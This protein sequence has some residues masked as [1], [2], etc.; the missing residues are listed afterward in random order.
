MSQDILTR[1]QQ[2][3]T[4]R[5]VIDDR[6]IK[7]PVQSLV[8]NDIVPNISRLNK[9]FSDLQGKFSGRQQ[10]MNNLIEEKVKQRTADL[11]RKAHF[12]ALTHLPNRAY[13]K[14]ITQQIL[15]RG[16]ETETTF[17][18]L[19][20]DLDGFKAVNDNFGHHIG[21]DLL[22]H[23]TA[24]LVSLV[25]ENDVVARIGGDEFVVLL[26][27]SDDNKDTVK[28]ICSRII[29]EISRVYFLYEQEVSVSASIGI[30]LFP[31]D[32]KTTSDLMKNADTALYLA[33]N[34]GKKQYRFFDE[35]KVNSSKVDLAK[36]LEKAILNNEITSRVQ[37][38]I[39]LFD[40]K[41]IGASLVPHWQT[42][43][44]GINDW[45][46]WKP[47]LVNTSSEKMIAEWLFDTACFYCNQWQKI[48][49]Q[50]IV[51]VPMLKNWLLEENIEN[52]LKNKVN[53]TGV[54]P[55]QIQLSISLAE[56]TSDLVKP[57]QNLDKT[58]FKICVTDFGSQE[59]DINLL[60]ELAI[61]EFSFDPK[62]LQAQMQTEQGQKW[63][64]ALIQMAK[65][66]DASMLA[67]G[68]Q[69]ES[70]CQQLKD[71]GCEIGQGSYWSADM[72]SEDFLPL[73]S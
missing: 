34:K 43:V 14:E 33:K 53:K 70:Y 36:E 24:R 8:V 10:E 50:F 66:L 18:L 15:Q 58:G 11:F 7:R 29:N 37:P 41:V 9:I 28:Q 56:L 73:L 62:W 6:Q 38:L 5:L 47:L 59:M 20:L 21:D 57:L 17:N 54:L 60:A 72:S 27:D 44:Q 31:Q 13:F 25:R 39:D 22:K 1:S 19:F 64:K 49:S 40:N 16:I 30:G 32:G 51:S 4:E 26:T 65:S 55:Q 42:A 23:A 63:I 71:W 68:I 2:A 45:E 3:S 61:K 46:S 69:S 35:V 12:D 48:D 52:T 67:K